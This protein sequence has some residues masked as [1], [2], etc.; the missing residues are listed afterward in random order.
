MH[1]KAKYSIRRTA[2]KL[3][4]ARNLKERLRLVT[5]LCARDGVKLARQL[6]D[7]TYLYWTSQPTVAVSAATSIGLLAKTVPDPEIEALSLWVDGIACIT[8]GKHDLALEKLDRASKLFVKMRRVHDSAQPKV[9]SLIAL[10]MLGR[11]DEAFRT[12]RKTLQIFERMGDQLAA[13]KIEMNLSNIAS[14]TGKHRVAETYCLSARGRFAALNEIEMLAMAEND[15]A[16]TYSELNEF[17]SAEKYYSSAFSR[18]R[19]S[20][21]LV[22]EAEIEANLGNLAIYR[23]RYG[24]A[25]KYLEESRRK[26]A[27]LGMSHQSAIAELEVADIYRELN[28]FSEA[29]EIYPKL[30]ATFRKLKMI[31]EEARARAGFGSTAFKTGRSK[32]AKNQLKAAAELYR[33]GGNLSGHADVLLRRAKLELSF[34]RDREALSLATK[35]RGMLR[36]TEDT[37]LKML[38]KWFCGDVMLKLGRRAN[39]RRILLEVVDDARS[40]DLRSLEFFALSSLGYDAAAGGEHVRAESYFKDAV[41]LIESIR[42]LLPVEEFQ[43]SFFTDKATVYI[44]LV[45][46]LL[47]EGRL[48]E[49]FAFLEGS[50][51]R[52][53]LDS[54]RVGNLVGSNRNEYGNEISKVRE[55]LNWYY[56]RLRESVGNEFADHQEIIRR[57]ETTLAELVRRSD[58][59]SSTGRTPPT[60]SF[61]MKSLKKMLGKKRALI[62]Y[63]VADGKY[64]AAVV[65]QKEC[66]FYIDL[67]TETELTGLI[68]DL[69]F[70]FNTLRYGKERLGKALDHLRSRCN[71]ILLMLFKA[72]LGKFVETLE[73]HDLVIVPAGSV[74]YVPFNALN[75][76]RRYLAESRSVVYAPAATIWME[77]ASSKRR[78]HGK[79]LLIG[80]ADE[81]IPMVESEI[82]EIS[83]VVPNAKIITGSDASWSNYKELT[84]RYD[85][86]HIACH[87]QFRADNPIYSSLHLADGWVTVRDI[88][89]QKLRARLVTLSACESGLNMIHAGEEILGL[90][91]GFL[92]AGVSSLVLSLWSVNDEAT[93]SLMCEFYTNLQNGMRVN[94]AL[95]MAQ[96]KFIDRGEHPF[97]WAPFIVVGK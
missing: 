13:G 63:F 81:Q 18:A 65:T 27:D 53:L 90:A 9:A 41:A 47:Q 83:K 62:E 15:L 89:E 78:D 94:D 97:Y 58:S 64:S 2:D 43:I 80:F 24:E 55:E 6:K 40:A 76:G 85:V 74:H 12:G 34:G 88:A 57:L 8:K 17:R 45:K 79:A 28:L 39:A 33:K 1:R 70:H 50:R 92:K 96:L 35:A 19:E 54:V 91:R 25:L 61:K 16:K 11:Y 93:A 56:S 20:G 49:A 3:I 66:Q 59:L 38:A 87:G 44:S 23:A 22:T 51:S 21:M 10:A 37:K 72:L 60:G 4:A 52:S 69:R 75:D 26:Y 36:T 73:D 68:D 77:L 71:E 29:L 95:K 82:Q 42:D 14:R 30:A 86:V 5:G 48:D 7:I 46:L 84:P 32:T 67:C 31:D